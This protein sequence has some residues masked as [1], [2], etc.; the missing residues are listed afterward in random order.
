MHKDKAYKW[1]SY[2]FYLYPLFLI[3]GSSVNNFFQIVICLFSIYII[4]KKEVI[5]SKDQRIIFILVIL[6]FFY[7][8]LVTF[9]NGN[10]FFLK[11]T[12]I[13]IKIVSF[14]IV[15]D[16]L[17][18]KKI[19][20]LKKFIYTSSVILIIV[21][22]DTFFQF[23]NGKNLI[24][25]E[26]EPNN[27]IRLTS[28]FKDEYVVGGF[29]ARIYLPIL[30]FF[31]FLIKNQKNKFWFFLIFSII[32]NISIFITGERSSIIISIL[33]FCLLF[34]FVEELRKQI[35]Y[36]LLF[37]IFIVAII[38]TISNPLKD[39]YIKGTIQDT[40]KILPEIKKDSIYNSQYGALY[41]TSLEIAKDNYLFG[42]GLRTYRIKSCKEDTKIY[43]QN[44]IN[45]KTN[46][47]EFICSTHPHNYIL[48]LILDL[49][50]IGLII[51]IALIYLILKRLI[52][53]KK[54]Q[55]K[56][57]IEKLC[58]IA[59]AL[60]FLSIFW[61]INTH[62]SIF[63]SWNSTFYLFNLCLFISL[64]ANNSNNILTNVNFKKQT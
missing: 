48:E 17:I 29:I 50:L 12:L 13:F 38:L 57:E 27:L 46:H 51:F 59:F 34:I 7:S 64:S 43:I 33:N 6:L 42:Q 31:T 1:L 15:I 4:F 20:D 5:I 55:N 22:F 36:K 60:H 32:I 44:K 62:G 24:G 9:Y 23:F 11:N 10:Y 63:S 35:F 45:K 14:C 61:P 40:L 25:F 19:F 21:I 18:S 49:G 8:F 41:L 28:F 58:I 47:S 26:I 52:L 37:S 16:F 54:N 3:L 53:F 56:S 39:R 30:I 2:I